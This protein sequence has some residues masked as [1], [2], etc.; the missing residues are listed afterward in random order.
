MP[1]PKRHVEEFVKPVVYVF[2]K[3]CLQ[4]PKNIFAKWG[5]VRSI[6]REG[7]LGTHLLV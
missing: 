7:G 2:V 4:V 3:N 1:N 5:L 6:T